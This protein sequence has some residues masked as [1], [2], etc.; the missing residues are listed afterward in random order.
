MYVYKVRIVAV[1]GFVRFVRDPFYSTS[2][3]SK[4][5]LLPNG[6][7]VQCQPYVIVHLLQASQSPV[8]NYTRLWFG[9]YVQQEP[10][11]TR[12]SCLYCGITVLIEI[13]HR[14][15]PLRNHSLRLFEIIENSVH[16]PVWYRSISNKNY[17]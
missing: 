4:P 14:T 6:D 16:M 15:T 10:R 11:L 3:L 2:N 7:S 9:T 12:Q 8:Y 1:V 5:Y 13:K 17:S